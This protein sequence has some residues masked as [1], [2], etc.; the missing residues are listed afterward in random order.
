M[1]TIAPRGS[2]E[3]N[4][5]YLVGS[6][7]NGTLGSSASDS[8]HQDSTAHKPIPH[9]EGERGTNHLDD[10]YWEPAEG[11]V[12]DDGVTRIE[13]L[14]LVYGKGW[15]LIALWTS[16]GLISYAYALSQST[17]YVCESRCVGPERYLMTDEQFA[18]SSFGTHSLIGTISVITAVCRFMATFGLV[19][20]H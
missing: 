3:A 10:A 7:E 19:F 1:T 2:A 18:A 9:E 4:V 6:S 14:Y 11:V 16:I 13:A 8:D 17:T 15:G 5:P 12:Q 20:T